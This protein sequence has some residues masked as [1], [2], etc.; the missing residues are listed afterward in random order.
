MKLGLP[1]AFILES[2][3]LDDEGL[4]VPIVGRV[5]GGGVLVLVVDGK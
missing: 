5:V 2:C 4:L 3:V 1:L